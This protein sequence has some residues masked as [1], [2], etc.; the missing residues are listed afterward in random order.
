[1]PSK[2]H[3]LRCQL[4]IQEILLIWISSVPNGVNTLIGLDRSL[5]EG[6]MRMF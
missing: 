6:I 3:E 4:S 1:M 5:A 2:A